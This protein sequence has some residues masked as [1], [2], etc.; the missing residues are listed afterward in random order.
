M[1][2]E[3]NSIFVDICAFVDGNNTVVDVWLNLGLVQH[4]LGQWVLHVIGKADGSHHNARSLI[5]NCVES[6]PHECNG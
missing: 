4:G 2:F 3:E 5:L 1:S 6:G